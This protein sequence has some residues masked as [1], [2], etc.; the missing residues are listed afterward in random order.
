MAHLPPAHGFGRGDRPPGSSG[1]DGG[2]DSKGEEEE[3]EDLEE[4]RLPITH[5]IENSLDTER[6]EMASQVRSR[7]SSRLTTE[8][9]A[10]E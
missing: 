3:E 6:I 2:Q 9:T 5:V 8:R 1:G 7:W 10:N 4:F